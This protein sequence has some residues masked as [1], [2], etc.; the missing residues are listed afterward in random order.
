MGAALVLQ[1]ENSNNHNLT[2]AGNLETAL[3]RRG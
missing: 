2:F 1:P 3:V